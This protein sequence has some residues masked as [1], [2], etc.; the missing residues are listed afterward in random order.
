MGITAAGIGA[1]FGAT[2]TAATVIG[3]G[4]IGAG[5]GAV[6]AAVT[7][8]PILKGA[9]YGAAGGAIGGGIAGAY[10]GAGAGAISD[11]AYGIGGLATESVAS[12]SLGFTAASG[13]SGGFLSSDLA[14]SALLSGGSQVASTILGKKGV[15]K[16]G[17]TPTPTISPVAAMP[18]PD[19]EAVDLARRRSL[20]TQI[21]RL[22][23]ASTMLSEKLGS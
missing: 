22:G 14:K 17:S 21:S 4:V 19:S 5:V 23:R 20:A 1:Y 16:V 8:K 6:G 12:Q 18:L 3:S 7:D 11:S 10:G 13:A 9:L 15:P 2:G